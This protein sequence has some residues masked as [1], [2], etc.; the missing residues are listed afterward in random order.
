LG[1]LEEQTADPLTALQRVLRIRSANAT[2]QEVVLGCPLNNLAQEMS[3]LDEQFR[4]RINAAFDTWRKGFAQALKRGQA[5]GTVRPEVDAKGVASFLVAAVEGFVGLAKS[6]KSLPMLRSNYQV[7][8]AFLDSLRPPSRQ[9]R[10]ASA[11]P[12]TT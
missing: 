11:R 7:L 4:R 6:A 12:A 2:A 9:G 10:G 8:V 1:L 5:E 3:P